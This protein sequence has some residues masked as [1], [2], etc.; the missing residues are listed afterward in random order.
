[1]SSILRSNQE[2]PWWFIIKPP[3][4]KEIEIEAL[5]DH[6]NKRVQYL[7]EYSQLKA[8]SKFNN[9]NLSNQLLDKYFPGLSNNS[10]E[11]SKEHFFFGHWF[12]RISATFS[13]R[14]ESW[15]LEI[16]GDLFETFFNKLGLNEK[17]EIFQL[18]AESEKKVT[19]A[20]VIQNDIFIP[21]ELISA[22]NLAVHW[23]LVPYL[24]SQKKG[25][26]FN[27][28]MVAPFHIFNKS[29]KKLF[30]KKLKNIIILLKRNDQFVSFFE[31]NMLIQNEIKDLEKNLVNY[32]KYDTTNLFFDEE[33]IIGINL[34]DKLEL[35][36]PCMRFLVQDMKKMGYIKHNYRFQL[37]LFLKRIGM[38]VDSQLRFWYNLAVDNIGISFDQFVKRAGYIIRHIYG[39]EG[40]KTDYE[41]PRCKKIKTDYFCL[42]SH[43]NTEELK[44]LLPKMYSIKSESKKNLMNEL[45][46][47]SRQ[48]RDTE[49][50][51]KTFQV[52]FNKNI[53]INHPLYWMRSSYNISKRNI[54]R[55]K[56]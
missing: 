16:E 30:E 5:I 11:T 47:L 52:L 3:K 55:D 39:L 7:V 12:L 2:Y 29:V 32:S 23:S 8:D 4:D 49:A 13:G 9:S 38:D 24:V 34:F 10:N 27:G 54:D 15:L 51:S 19:Y 18:L 22:D 46:D 37:G 40:S 36:P 17:L 6:G 25:A 28:Y 56:D 14:I 43:I 48:H 21:N 31:T 53:R 26:L 45:F 35:F 41:V 20:K 42:F 44:N 33:D 50:C 1:M